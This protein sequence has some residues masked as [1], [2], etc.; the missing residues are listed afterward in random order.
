L[1]LLF[2]HASITPSLKGIEKM[3]SRNETRLDDS[4]DVNL[5]VNTCTC[6]HTTKGYRNYNMLLLRMVCKHFAT[7][8]CYNYNTVIGQYRNNIGSLI[9]SADQILLSLNKG[10]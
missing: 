8:M 6:R 1:P 3:S 9:L 4:V 2:T 7:R 10:G 5:L